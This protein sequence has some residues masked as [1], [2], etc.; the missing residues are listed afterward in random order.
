MNQYLEIIRTLSLQNKATQDYISLCELAQ[1]RLV[2]DGYVEKHHILPKCIC[3]NDLQIRDENNL[4]IFSA[5]EHFIAHVLLSEMF[6]GI[7]RRKMLYALSA[8]SFRK[9]GLRV[10]DADDYAITKE[11]SR[12][13]KKGIPL[14]DNHKQKIMDS[15]AIHNPNKGRKVSKETKFKQSIAKKGKPHIHSDETRKKLSISRIGLV[16]DD[17]ICPHC[18]KIGKPGAL[19]RWHFD[20]CKARR[21]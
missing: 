15:F 13:A 19:G 5:K 7:T 16:I 4:V 14:T 11:A 20:N 17:V 10:L 3:A 9:D 21:N 6:E 18:D 2:I 12:L 1:E 8:L